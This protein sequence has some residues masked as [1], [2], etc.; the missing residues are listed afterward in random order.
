MR[1]R[2]SRLDTLIALAVVIVLGLLALAVVWALA[3]RHLSTDLHVSVAS[4]GDLVLL[5]LLTGVFGAALLE[6]AKRTLGLRS[7]YHRS[8]LSQF[9]GGS[10]DYADVWMAVGYDKTRERD[11]RSFLDAPLEQLTAQL[12]EA[13]E[14]AL[15]DVSKNATFLVRLTGPGRSEA[16]SIVELATLQRTLVSRAESPGPSQSSE[17]DVRAARLSAEVRNQIE[18]RLDLFQIITRSKWRR[19]CQMQACV[20]SGFVAVVAVIF[21]GASAAVAVG[22]FVVGAAVGGFFAWTTRDITAWIERQRG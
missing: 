19:R 14:R 5:A 18:R 4:A 9:F 13:A 20:L 6:V 21:A 12:G 7:V 3:E 10:S 17:L 2:S 11:V 16:D 8:A 22:S 15:I 1:Y